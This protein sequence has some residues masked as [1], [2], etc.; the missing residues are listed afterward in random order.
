MRVVIEEIIET[1]SGGHAW[2]EVEFSSGKTVTLRV[3]EFDL[4]VKRPR[5][6]TRVSNNGNDEVGRDMIL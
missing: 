2:I 5:L 1:P 6:F 3:D 4:H